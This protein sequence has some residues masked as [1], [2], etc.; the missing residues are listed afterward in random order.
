MQYY[1]LINDKIEL[2]SEGKK[3][4]AVLGISLEELRD[5]PDEKLNPSHWQGCKTYVDQALKNGK[6]VTWLDDGRI[7]YKSEGWEKYN[8]GNDNPD[9]FLG[10]LDDKPFN[11]K[12]NSQGRFPANLLVSDDVLNDGRIRH[13]AGFP[14]KGYGFDNNYLGHGANTGERYGDSGSFSRY[15]SLDSWWEKKLKELPTGVQKT[16][17]FLIVPKASKAE[18]NR[19]CEGMKEKAKCDIDKMG[20]A[21]CTMKT[22]S[23]NKRNVMYKNNHPTCKPLKLMSYLITLGS[24]RGDII[25]DPFIGSGTTAIAAVMMGRRYIGYETEED[26]VKIANKRLSG[27]QLSLL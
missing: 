14:R 6:G 4:L 13:S 21:K 15:F 17:P 7:P 23:G 19:G 27:V 2:T 8:R 10:G 22:G 26:Y 20:G 24:R 18:K 3:A 9:D 11:K 25:L 16:F 5:Y 1:K 12:S